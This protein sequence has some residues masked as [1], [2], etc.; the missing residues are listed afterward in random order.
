MNT[1]EYPLKNSAIL[2]SGTTLHIF[3]QIHRFSNYKKALPGD[4]L[5][6]GTH[7]V[8]IQ[9]YGDVV[10]QIKGP[11]H[12]RWPHKQKQHFLRLRNVAYCPGFACNL[13]SLRKLRK[14]GLWWDNSPGNNCIRKA[15]NTIICYLSDRYSQFVLEDLPTTLSNLA[16]F[17]TR[18]NKFNTYTQRRP[19]KA[20]ADLW[21]QRLGHPGPQALEQLIH[22]TEGVRIKGPTTVQC[23]ACGVSKAKRRI[24]RR[25]REHNEG[26]GLRLAFDLH[27]FEEGYNGYKHLLL[28]TDRW[29]GLAWDYYFKDRA[30]ETITTAIS[31]L[32]SC[33][34]QQYSIRPKVVECDNELY[35]PVFQAYFIQRF[36]QVEPSAPYTQAQNGG[37]ERSGGVIKDKARTMRAGANLPVT[38]WPEITKAAVYLYNRTPKYDY[39]W[40]TPYDRFHTYVAHRDGSVIENRKPHQAHLR[41]YGCKA[42]AL[43]TEAQT[44][45]NRLQRLN[46]KAWI[47]YLVGYSSTNIYRI[48]NPLA[49]KVFS[50]RDVIFN[51]EEIFSGNIEALKSDC[52]HIQ[53]D[54]LQLLL[55]TVEEPEP[56]PEQLQ[57]SAIQEDEEV[58]STE[59]DEE[60]EAEE[61]AE[62]TIYAYDCAR[63]EPYPT[64]T[65]SPEAALLAGTIQQATD[66]PATSTATDFEPWMAAFAAGRLLQ[67]VEKNGQILTKAAVQRLA[68]RPQGLQGLYSQN[69]PP[70][71]KSHHQLRNHPFGPQFLQAEK[72]HLKSHEQMGSWTEVDNQAIKGGQILDCMWV[73]TYKVNSDGT[74]KNCKAR[75]VV[76]GDQQKPTAQE[77]YAATLAARSFRT[78]MAIAAR[79][80]LELVQWDAVNAFVNAR[81]Q[82]TVYMRMPT[83][84]R[85]PG[86][87]LHLHKALYGLR[88]SPLLWQKEL[89]A[90][91]HALG[92]QSIPHEPCI[93]IKNGI[94]V[95]FYVDDIVFAYRKEDT[96]VAQ[97]LT[98]QLRQKYQLTGGNNL[99]WFLGIKVLRDRTKGLIWL[100][101]TAYIDKI[102]TLATTK[103]TTK[104]KVPMA[105]AELLPYSQKAEP[106]SVTTYQQKTGSILYAAVIT[107]P[108]IA[109]AVSR[110]ARFN[111]NPSPEHHKAADQVLH[112]LQNTRKL[113]LQLGGGDDFVVASDASFADNTI[114]RK[115]SQ[116]Y[117]MK[118]FG[119]LIGWRANK[120]DTVTTSTTEA[121]LLALAQAT[122]E[123][124][125]ISRL[126]AELTVQLDK[127]HITIQCDNT[128]TIRLVTAEVATLQTKLRHVDIHNHWLRQEVNRKTI[129]VEYT[130]SNSMTADGLTKALNYPLHQRFLEQ[131]GITEPQL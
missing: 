6:A 129:K 45:S 109:F 73:Y 119:G 11:R 48:W 92:F 30:F 86:K 126:L 69:L 19:N 91:L 99:Q 16:F 72:D 75:L 100:S 96:A 118:L 40:K 124:L 87:V 57:P 42:F 111:A 54:E 110:L 60:G 62:S 37:A 33:L 66:L 90:A 41:A 108:D 9:G 17:V 7:P 128:Q 103:A 18:R 125:F 89:T 67:P 4:F 47:G 127:H 36:I 85:S 130:P 46:P 80:D 24:R 112:Y 102:V 83:G 53:L 23:D 8:Q 95:F 81:L 44:K 61:E 32:F 116:A 104:A 1:A 98:S 114:D 39:N 84:Y 28:A 77:T 34:D 88:Q 51:E 50:T 82:D 15:N 29:S 52:L 65:Q 43:T 63:F 56:D 123:G 106:Q 120:Q 59:E 105:T 93:L 38:L 25:P 55:S 117:T 113:A 122:K 70:L 64:P 2:D 121:E 76:R 21:H 97:D 94:L 14:Q 79:F 35:K 101:Q 107:R 115:S 22:H 131:L 5:W 74:F 3:N 58:Y 20:I 68:R 31:H 13:V 12:P 10:I 71:P 27:E 26:P 78:L 49:N